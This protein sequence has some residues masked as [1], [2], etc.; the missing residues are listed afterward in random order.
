MMKPPAVKAGRAVLVIVML[1]VAGQMA[2]AAL[3]EVDFENGT[4]GQNLPTASAQA[5]PTV[6]AKATLSTSWNGADLGNYI[7]NTYTDPDTDYV[8][9]D[10]KVAV[11]VDDT[12]TGN[13][14]D[15]Y[16]VGASN[17]E[18]TSGKVRVSWDMMWVSDTR[19]GNTFTSFQNSSGT[20]ICSLMWTSTELRLFEYDGAGS[21]S[22]TVYTIEDG[23]KLSFMLEFDLDTNT[24]AIYLNGS[25][26]S[27]TTSDQK[28]FEIP[29]DSDFLKTKFSITTAATATLVLDNF[30]TGPAPVM[31]LMFDVDFRHDTDGEEP[32]VANPRAMPATNTHPTY[33]T[34][35]DE[36]SIGNLIEDSYTDPTTSK[37]V[38]KGKV[39]VCTDDDTTD[40]LYLYF[41][42]ASGDEVDSG[43]VIVEWE[44]MWES[45]SQAGNSFTSFVDSNGTTICSLMWQNGS[46]RVNDDDGGHAV[47]SLSAG[48]PLAM[49]AIIDLDDDTVVFYKNGSILS[50]T[51]TGATKFAIASTDDYAGTRFSTTDT[52]TG[53]FALD[54][55]KIWVPSY[56][57]TVVED[58]ASTY[59]I[60]RDANAPQS[61]LDAATEIQAVIA[62]A[63]GKTLTIVST[64]P[65]S[66]P[67]ICVGDNSSSQTAGF[68]VTGFD[69]EEFR[70]VTTTDGNIYIFGK[71]TADNSETALEGFSR[72]TYLGAISFLETSLDARWLMPGT[73][74][75]DIPVRSDLAV[76]ACDLQAKPVFSGRKLHYIHNSNFA[77]AT[78]KA[79]VATW[80]NRNKLGGSIDLARGHSWDTFP[81][82][83]EVT[84]N[85]DYLALYNGSRSKI[86]NYKLCITNTDLIDAFADSVDDWLDAESTRLSVSI[87]PSDG[88]GWCEGDSVAVDGCDCAGDEQDS[89]SWQDY[90]GYGVSRSR[91]ILEFYDAVADIVDD[92]HPTK[93]LAGLVYASYGYPP[94]GAAMSLNSNLYLYW[95]PRPYYGMTL[96][97]SANASEFPTLLAGWADATSNLCYSSYP[98][99]VR[100]YVGAPIPAA[101]PIMKLIFPALREE[102]V[103]Q[104]VINSNS[105]WGHAGLHNYVAAKLLWDPDADADEIKDEWFERAY[106]PAGPHMTKVYDHLEDGWSTYMSSF[107]GWMTDLTDDMILS[108]YT[109]VD[110]YDGDGDN[111]TLYAAIEELYDLADAETLTTAQQARL[112]MFADNMKVFNYRLR[113]LGVTGMDT[114]DFYLPVDH[115]TLYDFKDFMSDEEDSLALTADWTDNISAPG[116][117]AKFDV[118]FNEVDVTSPS[119]AAVPTASATQGGIS[120]KATSC[121]T[122]DAQNDI[123]GLIYETYDDSVSGY[124]FGDENVVVMHDDTANEGFDLYFRGRDSDLA[125]AGVIEVSWKM[126]LDKTAAATG[127]F[128]ALLMNQEL[129]AI[130]GIMIGQGNTTLSAYEYSAAGTFSQLHSLTTY[131][132]GATISVRIV[133]DLDNDKATYYIDGV[134]KGEIDLPDSAGFNTVRFSSTASGKG[135]LAIDDF[136][137]DFP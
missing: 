83:T 29:A 20:N 47:G 130:G 112:D 137:I 125:I 11:M 67:M 114:S 95:A 72:G 57:H 3:F 34:A 25:Q 4:T 52:A 38:G 110:D 64:A 10:G 51:S 108:I 113:Q 23:E 82:D 66:D 53:I 7:A 21:T 39:L 62:A 91:M 84:N 35:W 43:Q 56:A 68:S 131:S 36:S 19:S 132:E 40:N 109:A 128:S 30:E 80:C 124:T 1:V 126:M 5:S 17:D 50:D 27:D 33:S 59:V 129:K 18:I 28:V 12:T 73:N 133:L 79:L 49:R 45:S 111:E 61:V 16:F 15:L 102:G 76:L 85:T 71:D 92:T 90:G 107:T 103:K 81:G 104:V 100:N 41:D 74:G 99:W 77:T 60:Y 93:K 70:V 42:A 89:G 101:M 120:T 105:A 98:G 9:G 55:L 96:Y 69:E 65:T 2:R 86:D 24:V 44:I 106:G 136:K 32:T 127:N 26:L 31:G 119:T 116:A 6:N 22:H 118:D 94:E 63:T 121:T 115:A 37:A 122:Y 14:P 58:D 46:L 117:I 97:K 8:F 78:N 13:N 135:I 87:S 123:G 54:N 88:D 75:E 134:Q 48:E